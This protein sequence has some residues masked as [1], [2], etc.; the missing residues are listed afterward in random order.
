VEE[1]REHSALS[2]REQERRRR[3]AMLRGIR[4]H[5]LI[6]LVTTMI[7]IVVNYL[8]TPAYPWWMWVAVAWGAPLAVHVAIAME[9]FRS[10]G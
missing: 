1:A 10:K 6:A 5:V 9:I 8:T 2:A 4:V 3:A 7:L